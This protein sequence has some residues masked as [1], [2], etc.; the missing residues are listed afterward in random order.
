M[1]KQV[2]CLVAVRRYCGR[3]RADVHVDASLVLV[4][5]GSWQLVLLV[6][7]SAP[8]RVRCHSTASEFAQDLALESRSI[9]PI[10]FNQHG[11]VVP[12]HGTFTASKPV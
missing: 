10:V 11:H 7:R 9:G 8:V 3:W 1:G 6:A 2:S 4:V 5:V 12:A